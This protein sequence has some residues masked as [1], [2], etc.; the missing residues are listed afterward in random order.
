[1]NGPHRATIVLVAAAASIVGCG[2]ATGPA[3]SERS[4]TIEEAGQLAAVQYD[5]FRAGG[6]AFQVAAAFTMSGDTLN[7]EGTIDWENHVGRARVV[8]RG[9]EEGIVE[10]YWTDD[11]VLERWPAADAVLTRLGYADARYLARSPD[12]ASRLLDRVLGIL[13][14]LASEQQD[15]PVLIQQ[16]A[17]SAF[18]RTDELKGNVV[19]V[20]RYGERNLYWIDASTRQLL[21]FEGNAEGGSA[22]VIVDLLSMGTQKVT[23][24][25]QNQVL[26]TSSIDDLY[27]ALRMTT[28]SPSVTSLGSTP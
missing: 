28:T 19:T 4:L 18:V 22:P 6:A 5:N 25:L 9:A 13:L 10:V 21:R 24:P 14:A 2:G 15:N 27:G 8:A 17:G 3:I 16:K 20:L 26:D 1:M 11:V 7:L 12:P 23:L